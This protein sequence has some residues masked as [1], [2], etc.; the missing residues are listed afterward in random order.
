MC[1]CVCVCVHIF[2]ICEHTNASGK[3]GYTSSL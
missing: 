2:G 3:Q 1:V